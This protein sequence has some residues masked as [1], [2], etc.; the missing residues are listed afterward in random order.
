MKQILIL[1]F[2][3]SGFSKVMAQQAS[4]PAI[5]DSAKS[6]SAKKDSVRKTKF[7]V[8]IY[9][10]PA[11]NKVEINV[12]GF[13]PG[14]I[15]LQMTDMK[16]NVIRDDKRLLV[17]G[18]ELITLMFSLQPGMYFISLKQRGKLVRKKLLVR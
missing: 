13:E 12:E 6:I 10:N 4:A 15:Q 5:S 8:N 17:S 9:P 7:N 14:F 11:K 1:F 3:F 18:N 16:G 2:L